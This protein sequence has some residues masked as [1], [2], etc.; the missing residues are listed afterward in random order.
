ME[1]MLRR[2]ARTLLVAAALIVASAPVAESGL[3]L[4]VVEHTLANGMRFYLVERHTSPTVAY[5]VSFQVGSRLEAAGSTGISHLLEHMMF[6]G[7]RQ[8]GTTDYETEAPLIARL[9]ELQARLR[10][11]RQAPEPDREAIERTEEAVSALE[12]EQAR[13]VVKNELS[14]FY[15]S[16]G[17]VSFNAGTSK[18]GTH[19]MVRLPSNKLELW[20]YLES[21]RMAD[22]VLREFYR[23]RDVVLEERRLR[24]D[25]SPGG[26]LWERF[27]AAA[28]IAHP[29]GVPIIGWPDDV[30]RFTRPEVEAY[31]QRFYAPNNAIGVIVGDIDPERVIPML[32]RTFGA[33]PRQAPPEVR[34]PSE[35]PQMGERRVVVRYEAEPQLMVGYHVPAVTHPDTYPLKVLAAILADGRTSRFYERLIDGQ[36]LAVAAD[37]GAGIWKDPGLFII[38]ATPRAPHTVAELESAIADEVRRIQSEPPTAWELEKTRNQIDAS[39]VHQFRSNLGI[40]FRVS[41]AVSLTGDWRYI[42]R[43]RELLK[44]VTAD[45]VLRV[46]RDYLRQDNRTVAVLLSPET[47]ETVKEEAP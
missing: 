44:A 23:E 40:A 22:P 12:A 35:P 45:D 47:K 42:E 15:R 21:D 24:I 38:S 39:A 11:L 36:R 4:E 2:T 14:Q 1:I 27:M 6:K 10:E 28:Y 5:L 16:H 9:D 25:T 8:V 19:Y 20:A 31:F 34:V 18:D 32:E 17:G 30:D 29:Y 3:R 7:T 13:Y 41:R 26:L 33:I 37:A 43:E 46:A